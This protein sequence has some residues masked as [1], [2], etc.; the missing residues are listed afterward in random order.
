MSITRVSLMQETFNIGVTCLY[1][2]FSGCYHLAIVDLLAFLLAKLL[3]LYSFLII[4]AEVRGL[5]SPPKNKLTEGG[6]VFMVWVGIR[7]R[8]TR[9][10]GKKRASGTFL[11]RRRDSLP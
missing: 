3:L 4:S 7:T 10:S 8:A 9:V 11:A 1:A 6:L 5:L 2:V